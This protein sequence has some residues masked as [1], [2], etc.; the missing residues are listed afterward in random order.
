MQDY[1]IVA[2]PAGWTALPDRFSVRALHQD[3]VVA[4]PRGCDGAGPVAAMRRSRRVAY[5]DPEAPDAVSLQPHPE[6]GPE[7]MDELLA[8]RAGT[9]FPV[10]EA[11]DGAGVAGAAGRQRGLGAADRRPILAPRRG[12]R[13]APLDGR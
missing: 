1:E 7:F 4:L 6:F 13:P 8:L 5:G 3:Q 10:E 9:A 11:D 12:R 2:R